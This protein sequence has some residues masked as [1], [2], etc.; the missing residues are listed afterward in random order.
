MGENLSR[1]ITTSFHTLE[2][3]EPL[4]IIPEK[5]QI[6]APSYDGCLTLFD[7]QPGR[8]SEAIETS[9]TE[10]FPIQYLLELSSQEY[11]GVASD[12]KI[13][14]LKLQGQQ[15]LSV[16]SKKKQA[17]TTNILAISQFPSRLESTT[18]GE[19]KETI[20][21]ISVT[22][23]L[24]I[25]NLS[26]QQS[27]F[28]KAFPIKP[29][30]A[31]FVPFASELCCLTEDET[32]CWIVQHWDYINQT[33]KYE[34]QITSPEILTLSLNQEGIM[35]ISASGR[36]IALVQY[37]QPM[38]AFIQIIDLASHNTINSLNL[39]LRPSVLYALA[40]T[41]KCSALAPMLVVNCNFGISR[42]VS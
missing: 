38:E 11:I 41:N 19:S 8:Q 40:Q 18:P 25:Y 32:G 7:L 10:S 30:V 1:K 12:G 5:Q 3:M 24:E 34:W 37:L 29:L 42:E 2:A 9:K 17:T 26:T 14:H 16:S 13:R 35:A 6:L 31:H 15:D 28:L 20:V 33:V 22:G 4:I 23:E 27:S 36:M 39:E 21:L